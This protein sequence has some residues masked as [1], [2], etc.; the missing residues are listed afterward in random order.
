MSRKLGRNYPKTDFSEIIR[1]AYEKGKNDQTI[2]VEKLIEDIK[3]DLMKM[4]VH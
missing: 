1:K 2:T 4:K 3:L